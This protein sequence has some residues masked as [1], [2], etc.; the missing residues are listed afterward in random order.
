MNGWRSFSWAAGLLLAAC[1]TSASP[2][3]AEANPIDVAASQAYDLE[4]LD[5]YLDGERSSLQASLIDGTA[6]FPLETVTELGGV[7]EASSDGSSYTLSSANQTIV[8]TVGETARTVNGFLQTERRAAHEIGNQV[9]VPAVW[10]EEMLR[11]K[12]VNDSFTSSLYIF[13]ERNDGSSPPRQTPSG[14]NVTISEAPPTVT[15]VR[16]VGDEIQI[17]ATGDVEPRVFRLKSPERLVIDLPNA[18][19]ERNADGSASGSY[20]V[21]PD[22]PYVASIRYSLFALDPVTVRIAVDLKQPTW[23]HVVPSKGE[24]GAVIRFLEAEPVQVMI[25]AGHGGSDPGAISYSGKFEKDFTLP[26]ALKVADRLAEEALIQP[27][28]TRDDDTYT[29]PS[30]RA[31]RANRL[32]V[33]LFVSIHMNASDS[34][35]VKGTETY[36][37]RDDSLEFA[38]IVHQELLKAVG[39]SDRKVKKERFVV[40]RETTMPA[41]LLEIGFISNADEEEKLLNEQVQDRVAEAIVAAIKK[42]FQI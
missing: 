4:T 6:Y 37:W 17:E 34:R 9:Y 39:S 25:D 10:V 7:A 42:Y 19:V 3:H 21:D 40:V 33:D 28:L 31:A 11:V 13:R 18:T 22:H 1:V 15:G 27:I 26:I 16:L 41:V 36:Y 8:F 12:L 35:S 32:G 20:E 38:Q 2:A 24:P 5:V 30:E 14:S 23:Y 29:S